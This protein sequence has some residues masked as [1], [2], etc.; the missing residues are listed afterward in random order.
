MSSSIWAAGRYESVAERIASIADTVVAAVDSRRP[1]SEAA[2]VDLAC[3]TGSAA[4]AAARLGAR[5]TA[6]DITTDLLEIG[7]SKAR[8]AGLTVDWRTGDA[9]DT[10]LPDATADAVV[11]NMGIIFVEPQ[12]QVTELARL[13]KPGGILGFSSWVR[14][15]VNPLFDPIVAVLGTPPARGFTPDQWGDTDIATDRL[16]TQFDAVE[17][18]PGKLT[19]RFDSH[20]GA[21]SFVTQE[22]PMHVDI[23]ARAE[24]AQRDALRSAF[25]DALAAQADDGGGVSFD[26]SYVVVTAIRR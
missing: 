1:L 18:A 21:L 20:A 16:A 2:V 4:L 17:F 22:S 26:A 11:S 24:P 15:T 8:A 7:E 25:S 3:G 23:M 13:L 9:A 14:D 12:R 19:W 5:V 10:G 6:V